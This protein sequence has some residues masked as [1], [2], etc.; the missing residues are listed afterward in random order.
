MRQR[1]RA[2]GRGVKTMK[3]RARERK[4]EKKREHVR[5]RERKKKRGKKK[6]TIVTELLNIKEG[7]TYRMV[8]FS[9]GMVWY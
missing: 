8:S 4:R 7:Y 9:L 1:R 2:S 3:K 6:K 5:E